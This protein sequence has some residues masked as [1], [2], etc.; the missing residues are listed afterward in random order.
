MAQAALSGEELDTWW[1][2]L[3]VLRKKMGNSKTSGR[4]RKRRFTVNQFTSRIAVA[5]ARREPGSSNREEIA[6]A[7]GVSASKRKLSG[8]LPGWIDGEQ[9][10]S[11]ESD[12]TSPSTSNPD[13]GD[14]SGTSS[15]EAFEE[16]TE[17][18]KRKGIRLVD[19][20]RLQ[21]L[22]DATTVCKICGKGPLQL[23]ETGRT[24]LASSLTVECCD[25]ACLASHCAPLTHKSGQVFDVNRRCVLAAR[26]VGLGH[27]GLST[28]CGLMNIPPPVS[29]NAYRKHSR[30]LHS[31]SSLIAEKSTKTAARELRELNRQQGQDEVT[32]AVT[33]D[34]TWMKRGFSSMFGAF[35]C[36]SHDTGRVLDYTVCSKYCHECT[37]WRTRL[38]HHKVTQEKYTEWQNAHAGTC[39]T[40]T[41]GSSPA[42]EAEAAVQLWSRSE[43]KHGLQYRVFIGDGDSKAYSSVCQA[44]PYGPDVH[45][46]KEECVGHVQKRI[47]TNL[48]TLKKS[49][50]GQ[51]LEDGLKISGKGR[52]TD[53]VVDN[54]QRYYGMAIRSHPND[55]AGM[56]RAIW[57]S[58]SHSISTDD[59]PRH[60]FCP[61]TPDTW[62][63]YKRVEAGLQESYTHRNPIP[64]AI[65]KELRPLYVRLTDRPLLERCLRGATQNQNESFNST[66]WSL[67][68]KTGFC[69]RSVVE[70]ALN[71]AVA[72]FNYGSST[73]LAVLTEMGCEPGPWTEKFVKIADARRVAKAQRKEKQTSKSRRKRLR[74]R[75]KGLEEQMI[76]AEG[77]SYEAGG[78]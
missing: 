61:S 28:F 70:Q 30:A 37:I 11:S 58:L 3:L 64:M 35:I 47:G 73:L 72:R 76:E 7:E 10:S 42:M 20:S 51:L 9:S 41:L 17:E 53:E 18:L 62:C 60:E 48:R 69:S 36:I 12:L 54:L 77:P 23:T 34:G 19:L 75:K 49:R 59:R 22:F 56:Y 25:P 6:E 24:G 46:V 43:E 1:L 57:A 55:V 31:A 8:D 32:A 40:N 74:R 27:S 45:V 33:Y 68:P 63:G 39:S 16:S 13:S 2:L 66:V 5:S 78:H 26:S 52:L 71:L 15:S 67:C 65:F 21:E 50:K 14:D 38:E 4:P 44:Q 29:D